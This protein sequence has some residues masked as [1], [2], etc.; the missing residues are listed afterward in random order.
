M[1]NSVIHQRDAEIYLR[2]KTDPGVNVFY[3]KKKFRWNFSYWTLKKEHSFG[4]S[5]LSFNLSNGKHNI[6][7]RGDIIHKNKLSGVNTGF[8][9][10]NI[11]YHAMTPCCRYFVRE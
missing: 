8:K 6:F 2:C 1:L 10:L 3:W 4:M 7:Y 11:Q 5:T 9:M